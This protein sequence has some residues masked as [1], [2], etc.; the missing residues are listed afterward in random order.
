LATG[1]ILVAALAAYHNSFR[2]P[3]IF[4]DVASIAGNP[5]VCRLWPIWPVLLTPLGDLAVCRRPVANLSVAINYAL[6]GTDVWGYHAFNFVAHL[7]A[8]LTLFAVLQR[9]LDMPRL[10]GRLAA[11]AAPLALIITLIWTVHPLQTNAV[12]Y[13]IQRTEVL[14]GLFYLLTLYCVIR[15]AAAERRS[16]FGVQGSG[17]QGDTERGRVG[18]GAELL[19]SPS[20]PLPL[21]WSWYAGATVACLLAMGSK[22]SA[23]S[24]PVV[25]LAYDRVFLSRSW[26]ELWRRRWG[27]YLGLAATWSLT[28]AMVGRAWLHSGVAAAPAAAQGLRPWLEYALLQPRSIVWYLRLCFWPA[29]L[30]LDYGPDRVGSVAE[31]LPYAVVVAVLLVL[32]GV[33]LR[34]RPALGLLGVWFFLILAPSTGMVPIGPECAA[35]KRM[36]LPLAAVATLVV[37]CVYAAGQQ[38]SAGHGGRLG[39]ALGHGLAGLAVAALVLVSVRRNEDY[40]TELAIWQDDLEKSPNNARAHLNLGLALFSAGRVPEAISHYEQAAQLRPDYFFAQRNL[41]SALYRARRVPEAID[42]YE[43]AAQLRP[44]DFETHYNLGVALFSTGRMLQ[45]VSHYERAAQ[46]KPGD[47]QAHYNLGCAL[48]RAGRVPGA[49]SCYQRALEL[50]PDDFQT[51]YNL[52]NALCCAGRPSEA[53][54]HYERALQLRPDSAEAHD[55]LGNTLN[56]IGRPMEAIGHYEQASALRRLGGR[57]SRPADIR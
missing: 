16:E 44:D 14:A 38:L 56:L 9:T 45:A 55:N 42:R 31:V 57:T 3:L 49:I 51:R 33:A 28:A 29:P 7:L 1:V 17:R 2:G 39:R 20:S 32:T 27:L 37:W 36:Y 8:A 21:S 41:G 25:V 22:E 12:T 23:V 26:G 19:V 15:G 54:A 4:D 35:E 40:H 11:N 34:M 10:Q 13:I 30:I 43:Q 18:D 6:G 47:F 52:G 48:S 53:I 50:K 24:A 46:L 5:T